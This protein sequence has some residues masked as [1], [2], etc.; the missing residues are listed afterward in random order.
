MLVDSDFTVA[1]QYSHREQFGLNSTLNACQCLK[2]PHLSGL[3]K[4]P[5]AAAPD[6]ALA[7]GKSIKKKTSFAVAEPQK[8]QLPRLTRKVPDFAKMHAEQVRILPVFLYFFS[9]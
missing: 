2:V 4:T 6:M 1:W 3:A 8:S 5:V 7:S 9:F